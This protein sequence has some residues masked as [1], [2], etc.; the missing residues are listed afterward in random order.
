MK[1][2]CVNNLD[3]YD[4]RTIVYH[5]MRDYHGVKM[6]AEGLSSPV[7][8]PNHTHFPNPIDLSWKLILTLKK[9]WQTRYLT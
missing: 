6:K 1:R 7:D 9:F 2:I 5:E 3:I 4:F 8:N